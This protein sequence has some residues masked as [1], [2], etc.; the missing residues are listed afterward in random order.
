M[1]IEIDG[2][3]GEGGGQIL[4]S[5]LALSLITG[6]PFHLTRIRA[7]RPKPGL[8]AQHLTGVRAA[9][10]ISGAQVEGDFLGST[11][12][13]FRPGVPRGGHYH[14]NVAQ[15]RASAGAVSLVLQAILLPLGWAQ[16]ATTLEVAG[17]TH[18]AWSPPVDYL[19]QVWL[20][21][22]RS[23]GIRAA[24]EVFQW[25]FYPRGGG[26]VRVRVWP[27]E[28]PL[29]P[30]WFEDRVGDPRIQVYSI[31]GGLPES[32]AHRQLDR[33]LSRL[34]QMGLSAEGVAQRVN[35][36]GKGTALLIAA[37]WPS[38]L[39]VGFSA[40]GAPGKSAETVADEAISAFQAYWTT[41]G[42]LDPY[43]ADQV[44]VP[45]ALA[46]GTSRVRISRV[47]EHLRTNLWVVQQFLP[48]T[49]Q[50]EAHPDT[51][52]GLLT[53]TGVGWKGEQGCILDRDGL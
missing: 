53:L 17:G 12:L 48:V 34:R 11:E 33:A 9:T 14:L 43:L 36:P 13:W 37:T 40:L 30:L 16:E 20:P 4:R 31:A 29:R 42:A 50:L 25:G 22:L 3:H 44:V 21:V 49:F 8:Q 26:R 32:V 23:M 38:G 6:R 39:R 27:F 52:E 24:L 51:G 46:E 28:L 5:A 2:A 15:E 18:V 41:S 35:S 1:W 7:G 10:L 45:L 19:S 47:T